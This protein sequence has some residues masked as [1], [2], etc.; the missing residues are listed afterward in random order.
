MRYNFGNDMHADT[1]PGRAD[2]AMKEER[3]S[4]GI[5]LKWSLATVTAGILGFLSHAFLVNLIQPFIMSTMRGADVAQ[6]PY[7]PMIALSAAATALIP[8]GA[9]TAMYHWLGHN[10]P[11]RS[12]VGKGLWLGVLILLL[13]GE[14]I[15]QP[16]MDLLIG[17][18]LMVVALQNGQAVASNLI[19]ALAIALLMPLKSQNRP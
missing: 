16:L 15:R 6:P 1:G 12:R 5:I 8:V 9:L 3:G 4:A 2:G 11:A 19:A 17:N 13:K 14:L 10:I 7:P 18:P